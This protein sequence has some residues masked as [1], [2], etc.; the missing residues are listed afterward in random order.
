M[1]KS[2]STKYIKE[3]D[4]FFQKSKRGLELDS[5]PHDFWRKNFLSITYQISLPDCHLGT[6][7]TIYY[8]I[9][10]LPS[11]WRCKFWN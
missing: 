1:S 7:W 10:I 5:L 8:D 2:R 9:V 3:A 6:Y 11:L 4:H